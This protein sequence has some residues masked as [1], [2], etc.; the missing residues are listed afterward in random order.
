MSK[1]KLFPIDQSS[2]DFKAWLTSEKG[3]SPRAKSDCLARCRRIER[4]LDINL[5][6]F[7]QSA[8]SFSLLMS[9]IKEYAKN[10]SESPSSQYALTGT[11]RNAARK[12]ALFS[13]PK[14]KR[15]FEAGNYERSIKRS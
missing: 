12:Y 10:V 1:P 14:L 3:Y 13:N 7:F 9:N 15:T 6:D 4:E 2:N 5:S 11:L 8:E